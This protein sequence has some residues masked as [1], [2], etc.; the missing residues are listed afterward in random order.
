MKTAQQWIEHYDLKP[1][2]FGCG[3][4]KETFRSKESVEIKKVEG[5]KRSLSTGIISLFKDNQVTYLHQTKSHQDIHYYTGTTNLLVHL[6]NP[7]TKQ[8]ETV[9]LGPDTEV[10]LSI[11]SGIWFAFELESKKADSYALTG[12]TVTPGFDFRDFKLAE[13]H[14]LTKEFPSLAGFIDKFTMAPTIPEASLSC[15]MARDGIDAK[16]ERVYRA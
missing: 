3:F 10:M 16:S 4:F 14:L 8:K 9:I 15:Q 11:D 7:T 12:H 1:H 13:R 5:E 6:I 2:P